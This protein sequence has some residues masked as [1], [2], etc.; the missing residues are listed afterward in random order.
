MRKEQVSQHEVLA[1]IREQGV[2]NLEDVEAVVLE[3]DAAF[4]ITQRKNDTSEISQTLA[5]VSGF[6]P[7]K[8]DPA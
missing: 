3:V 5:N 1:A 4:I 6:S 2:H 8:S 7:E